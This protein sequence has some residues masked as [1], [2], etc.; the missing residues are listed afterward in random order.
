MEIVFLQVTTNLTFNAETDTFAMGKHKTGKLTITTSSLFQFGINWEEA[1]DRW[2][3][4]CQLHDWESQ[5]RRV[6]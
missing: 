3:S 6:A 1:S 4:K 2:G 5:P